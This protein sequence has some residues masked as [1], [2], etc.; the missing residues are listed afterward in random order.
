MN[1]AA[2]G[3]YIES[4][5]FSEAAQEKFFSAL[6]GFDYQALN[7]FDSFDSTIK[8]MAE[9]LKACGPAIIFGRTSGT[10][11]VLQRTCTDMLAYNVT[12][13]PSQIKLASV[14]PASTNTTIRFSAE[15]GIKRYVVQV[16]F[17]KDILQ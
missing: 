15:K 12:S 13:Q 6:R 11:D 14:Q 10:T 3:L 17:Y 8:A 7:K 9:E 1:A 4:T 5:N 2:N 16:T